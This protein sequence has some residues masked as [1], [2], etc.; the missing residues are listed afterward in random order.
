MVPRSILFVCLG[1]ICRS[2]LAEGIAKKEAQ[3]RGLDIS[4][5]SCGTSHY[6]VG[7][8][9]C[10]NSIKIAAQNGVDISSHRARQLCKEDFVTFDIIVGM[11]QNNIETIQQMTQKKIYKLGDFGFKGACVPDPYYFSGFEGFKKVYSMI[12]SCVRGLFDVKFT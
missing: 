9:P 10:M 6:H 5:D 2:P 1:N 8:A 7:E 4:I 11:D 12:E 3:N